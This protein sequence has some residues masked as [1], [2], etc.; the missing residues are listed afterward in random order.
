MAQPAMFSWQQPLAA[1]FGGISAA[2]QPG[3]FANFGAGVNQTMQ[4]QQQ[5]AQAQQMAELRDLEIQQQQQQMARANKEAADRAA[6]GQ[7]LASLVEGGGIQTAS[8]V[9]PVGNYGAATGGVPQPGQPA[10]FQNWSPEQ[11]AV[12]VQ[13]ARDNPDA[14]QQFVVEQQFA[15]PDAPK[16]VGGMQWN[17]AT[18]GFEPIPGYTEQAAQIAAA[19]RTPQQP[20]PTN[21]I[22]LVGPNGQQQ[23][24]DS[25]DP[26]VKVLANQGWTERQN[27]MFPAAPSGY[28][29]TPNG[30]TPIPG[31]PADPANPNNITAD[32]RKT[33]SFAE[34]LENSNKIID[35]NEAVGTDYTQEGLSSIPLVG[36]LL[37]SPEK[38]KL[39]QAQ[40]DFVN[41]Q[42]RRESGATI[43]DSEFDSAVKQYFPQPGEGPEIIAQKREA[44]RIAIENM[45]REAG[46]AMPQGAGNND[47]LGI[48]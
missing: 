7:Q 43:Q 13:F 45:K 46:A 3:G 39:S 11:R 47:P 44:R 40:R 42:L 17:Q 2:G 38:Q 24:F 29:Y 48:R 8:G 10:M 37:A 25:R 20:M 6:R 5:A 33:S 18:G 15:Q 21:L 31:G 28:S 36:T 9:R 12:F 27:S 34:R 1:L 16:T 32:Q 22:T 4:Q 35:E 30:L 14:A 41:A 26:Q 19:G 23:S